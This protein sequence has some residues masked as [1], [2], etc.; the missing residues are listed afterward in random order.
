MLQLFVW[1]AIFQIEKRPF[2]TW[3][4]ISVMKK[5][6]NCNII[7]PESCSRQS[8]FSM[9]ACVLCRFWP[10]LLPSVENFFWQ[11]SYGSASEFKSHSTKPCWTSWSPCQGGCRPSLVGRASV[12]ST[13][14]RS[15]KNNAPFSAKTI[16]IKRQLTKYTRCVNFSWRIL[17]MYKKIAD[18]MLVR[19]ATV[20]HFFC[21]IYLHYTV[22]SKAQSWYKT[23]C[24]FHWVK[25]RLLT[26]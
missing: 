23:A 8:F 5:S 13:S 26:V 9:S 24:N 10:T 17:H 1:Q 15:F 4:T 19:R 18:T 6:I 20:I 22:T 3:M 25:D 2:A 7:F 12:P 14:Q 11:V 16:S 21:R